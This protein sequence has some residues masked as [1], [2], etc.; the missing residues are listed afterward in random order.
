P[1]LHPHAGQQ[2][3]RAAQG[4]ARSDRPVVGALPVRVHEGRLEPQ[5]RHLLRRDDLLLPAAV[6]QDAGSEA[7]AMRTAT[8]WWASL[9][10]GVGLL[11]FLLGERLFG[12]LSGVRFFLTGGGLLLI[13]GIAA[14]RAWALASSSGA[15]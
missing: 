3:R 5:G 13:L 2:G 4:R 14:D 10:F 9:V 11:L 12:H 6:D 1:V 8:P 15:R 7:M